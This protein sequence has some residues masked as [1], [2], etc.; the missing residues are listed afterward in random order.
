MIQTTRELTCLLEHSFAELT[1][2][3]DIRKS[4]RMDLPDGSLVV[5]FNILAKELMSKISASYLCHRRDVIAFFG[6][7]IIVIA[8][9]WELIL[10][11]NDGDEKLV[12]IKE[13]LLWA[14]HYMKQAPHF[15]VLCKTLKKNSSNTCPT[16]KTVSK[17]IWF[18]VNEICELQEKVIVWDNRKINDR[19][20]DCLVS[21]DGIDCQFQQILIDHPTEPGKKIHNKAL[22]SH[23][24]KGPGLRYEV[25]LSLL[26]DDIVWI[27]G[28]FMPGDWPDVSIFR[29]DLMHQLEAGERIEADDGYKDEAPRKVVCP[30]SIATTVEQLDLMKRVEGRHEV[31]NKHIKNWKC[32]KGNF[33]MKGTPANKVEKH[34]ILFYSC[35]IVKQV[36]MQLGVGQLYEL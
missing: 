31:M 8:K 13:H 4:E 29:H 33:E 18:Y 10:E 35:V 3:D 12:K 28:P 2:Q 36:S 5:Q 6:A 14:L 24:F 7:P 23:K 21:V 16:R 25:A 20:D 9:L 17:W 1:L 34:R 27:N 22:Y 11:N 30:C 26:S 32:M 19:G 15:S